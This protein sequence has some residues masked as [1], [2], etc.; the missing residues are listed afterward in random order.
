VRFEESVFENAD[1]LLDGN[2]YAG[3]TF[4]RCRLIFGG[5]ASVGMKDNLLVECSWIFTGAAERT[6]AFMSALYGGGATELIEQTFGAIRTGAL[7][8]KPG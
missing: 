6:L 8:R 5:S 2:E 1:I 4:R 7:P 3:C